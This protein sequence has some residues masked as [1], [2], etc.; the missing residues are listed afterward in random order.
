MP[1]D[2]ITKFSIGQS[3]LSV[4]SSATVTP[5]NSDTQLPDLEAI[6]NVDEVMQIIVSMIKK[7]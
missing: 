5:E 6:T 4:D 3:T 7:R 1:H 2:S